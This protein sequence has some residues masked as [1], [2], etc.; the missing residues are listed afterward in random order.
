MASE[1][2]TSGIVVQSRDAHGVVRSASVD[3][4]VLDATTPLVVLIDAD[5]ASAAEVVASALQDAARAKLVGE[6]TSGTG[7]WLASVSL[8]DGSLLEIGTAEWLTRNG[9]SV[10]QV[11]VAPNVEVAL[12]DRAEP[13]TPAHFRRSG[14]LSL[15]SAGDAQLLKAVQLLGRGGS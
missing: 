10:W 14:K 5:S 11:G 8:D 13:V 1:F 6:Q 4:A 15:Q 2:I 7:T 12:P 3:R 9:R